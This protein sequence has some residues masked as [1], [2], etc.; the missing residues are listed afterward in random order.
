MGAHDNQAPP[1]GN[2]VRPLE[3]VP[4]SDH[5]PVVCQPIKDGEI[6]SSFLNF[7]EAMTSKANDLTSQ[8]QAMKTYVNR[9]VGPR[10]TQDARTMASRVRDFTRMN[11]LMFLWSRED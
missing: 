5:V 10:I 11:P 9:E 4:M 3:Q 8:V 7:V 2:Q 6:R 1:Q